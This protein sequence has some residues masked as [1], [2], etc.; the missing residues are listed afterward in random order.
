VTRLRR[1]FAA[2][3]RELS[4]RQEG[5]DPHVGRTVGYAPDPSADYLPENRPVSSEAADELRRMVM[6][7]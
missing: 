6:G 7:K 4:A 3:L 1:A 5:S 2:F